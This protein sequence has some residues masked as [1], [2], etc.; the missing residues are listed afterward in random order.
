MFDDD[1]RIRARRL[2]AGDYRQD[3]LTHLYLGLRDRTC[4]RKTFREIGDFVAHRKERDQGLIHGVG[5]DILTSFTVWAMGL[6]GTMPPLQDMVRCANANFKLA[7]DK[8]IKDS[9]GCRRDVAR[10]RLDRAIVQ[11]RA[12]QPIENADDERV[13]RALRARWIWRPA[14][15]ADTLFDD[16]TFVLR[17]NDI[18]DKAGCKALPIAKD[19][20]TLHAVKTM[21][22]SQIKLENGKSASLHAGYANRERVLEVKIDLTYDGLPKPL[23]AP[24]CLFLTNLCGRTYCEPDLLIVNDQ[25]DFKAWS[26]P[27]DI[28]PAMKIGRVY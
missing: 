13:W 17:R 2:A 21:H 3:D 12:N 15:S 6:N 8:Q 7:T 1:L 24:T 19:F 20:V 10:K 18:L 14:F 4:G 9:C 11:L 26:M 5:K 28:T 25:A 27:I 16:L 23:T 22:G